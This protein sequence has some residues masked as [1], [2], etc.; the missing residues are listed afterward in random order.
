MHCNVQDR[1]DGRKKQVLRL[2]YA[3][4]R[5]TDLWDESMTH[6]SR[7]RD[8][9]ESEVPNEFPYEVKVMHNN[10]SSILKD[11]S[12]GNRRNS[13]NPGSVMQVTVVAALLSL[14]AV[15]PLHA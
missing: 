13:N 4:L 2:R 5:M 14:F 9:N 3:S 11:M 1:A 6:H 8:K 12:C 15:W 10:L 7:G